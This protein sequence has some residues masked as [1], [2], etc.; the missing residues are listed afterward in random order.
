MASERVCDH[1]LTNAENDAYVAMASP[2]LRD[3]VIVSYLV[4][5]TACVAEIASEGALRDVDS[6]L[7]P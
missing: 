6:G 7:F 5:G 4:F 1:G 2:V 3:E